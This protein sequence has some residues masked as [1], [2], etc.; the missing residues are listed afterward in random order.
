MDHLDQIIENFNIPS[1]NFEYSSLTNG[2]INDT[3][4]VSAD[5]SPLYV[6]QK[7]NTKVFPQIDALTHNITSVL[8]KLNH[9]DYFKIIL[10]KT[11][12]ATGIFPCTED[13]FAMTAASVT[14]GY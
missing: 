10:E 14:P 9:K 11:T 13:S 3:Y 5:S 2:L 6:L 7:I 12:N 8:P 4:L 1:R